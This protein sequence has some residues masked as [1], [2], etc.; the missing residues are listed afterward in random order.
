MTMHE[1]LDKLL[2]K[3]D[4]SL[5]SL[6][7]VDVAFYAGINNEGSMNYTIKEDGLYFICCHIHRSKSS[8]VPTFTLNGVDLD[9]AESQI[10][11][12]GY[13]HVKYCT[14]SFNASDVL[15]IYDSYWYCGSITVVK[16]D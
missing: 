3:V 11:S 13:S 2:N 9:H 16:L 4:F 10:N 1:K 7:N 6:N 15:S 12:Y 8:S 14:R 5:N